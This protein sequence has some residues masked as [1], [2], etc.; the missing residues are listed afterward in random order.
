ME[1]G[2]IL[3]RGGL[4]R[5]KDCKP[6]GTVRAAVGKFGF[7]ECVTCKQKV[8]GKL[9]IGHTYE[10]SGDGL[11]LTHWQCS[12]C[13]EQWN[14]PGSL[15]LKDVVAVATFVATS[16]DDVEARIMAESSQLAPFKKGGIKPVTGGRRRVEAGKRRI[17]QKT[18]SRKQESHALLSLVIG[19]DPE[20]LGLRALLPI[21]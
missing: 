12:K 15:E 9:K 7:E 6:L 19:L 2:P 20:C 4:K 16:K 3:R 14:P 13:F 5:T 18:R 17:V 1:E 21:L 11:Q 10:D 8:E